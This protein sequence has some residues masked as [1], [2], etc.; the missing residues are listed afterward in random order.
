MAP[1]LCAAGVDLHVA[2]LHERQG[3]QAALRQAGVGIHA[4]SGPGYAR[5]VVQ[6]R[7]LIGMLKPDLVH[8]TLAEAD[9]VGRVAARWAGV[10]AITSLVSV[11]YGAEHYSDPAIHPWKLRVWQMADALTAYRRGGHHGEKA[12]HPSN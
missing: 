8:T 1:F 7:A 9:L 5:R 4:V 10:P 2:Y 3:V 6:L 12:S 11:A